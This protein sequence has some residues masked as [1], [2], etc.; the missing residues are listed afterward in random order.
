MRVRAGQ[1]PPGGSG[2][3]GCHP[4]A[5]FPWPLLP[6][7]CRPPFGLLFLLQQP[8]RL[9]SLLPPPS[10]PL[11]S[12]PCGPVGRRLDSSPQGAPP[13]PP[14]HHFPFSGPPPSRRSLFLK[15]PQTPPGASL[16]GR[17]AGPVSGLHLAVWM[18]FSPGALRPRL[19]L[20]SLLRGVQDSRTRIRPTE[21]K[22]RVRERLGAPRRHVS[23]AG[24]P[25]RPV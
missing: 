22:M 8:S 5:S 23:P 9:P 15:E 1:R 6:L 4:H 12:C 18:L 11:T 14:P 16:S 2:G 21:Q 3:S 24:P 13:S 7:S 19:C 10:P 20:R 17:P 25:L